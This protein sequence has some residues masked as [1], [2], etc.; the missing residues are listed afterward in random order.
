[1]RLA[2]AAYR[3]PRVVTIDGASSRV[4]APEQGI[5]ARSGLATTE[6]RVALIRLLDRLA[7]QH[8]HIKSSMYVDNILAETVGTHSDVD[9]R[10][11]EAGGDL[12][13]GVVGLGLR[14][15][16]AGKCVVLASKK[17]LGQSIAASLQRFGIVYAERAKDLGVGT[18]AGIR[19]NAGVQ[20]GRWQT[21]RAKL[22]KF[23]ALMR[24]GF[25]TARVIVTGA[26]ATFT[27][28]DDVTGVSNTDLDA[29]RRTVA[30]MIGTPTR[31]K[32]VDA[33]LA[34][35]ETDGRQR[36]DPAFDAH[37]LPLGRWAEAVWSGWCPKVLL[38]NSVSKAK[39]QLV[40]A[41]RPWATVKGLAAAAAPPRVVL[42][43]RSTTRRRLR[44]TRMSSSTWRS[45]PPLWW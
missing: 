11:A 39:A 45:T 34:L 32:D 3:L 10:M 14:L 15:S 31:G 6:L 24:A 9:R 40:K 30:A 8:L 33:V 20:R 13:S 23:A 28:G 25:N 42:A 35:A 22:G 12:C 7:S 36:V 29:R 18:A 41:A 16:A 44:R 1:M 27:Y 17:K 19:R 2:I 38:N 37:T 21:F 26:A 4:V 5:A 43:G